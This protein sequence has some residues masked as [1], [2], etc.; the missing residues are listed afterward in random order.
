[1]D[2]LAENLSPKNAKDGLV[3][4]KSTNKTP[5]TSHSRKKADVN[6]KDKKVS[7][8]IANSIIF[9]INSWKFSIELINFFYMF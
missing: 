4:S 9:I 2:E 6:T 8:F 7:F 1:M 5:S 3:I